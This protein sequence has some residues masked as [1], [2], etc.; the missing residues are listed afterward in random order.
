MR[1][2]DQY[3]EIEYDDQ[4]R[5]YTAAERSAMGLDKSVPEMLN[6]IH[7]RYGYTDTDIAQIFKLSREH[8]SRLRHGS[9]IASVSLTSAI[10]NIYRDILINDIPLPPKAYD[11][12]STS[13]SLDDQEE[14]NAMYIHVPVPVLISV[15][16]SF[17]I[18]LFLFVAVHNQNQAN[19]LRD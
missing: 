8:V 4:P 1:Y 3:N 19:R 15:G 11:R 18:V 2:D 12:R 17:L 5:P 10:R 13:S 16:V 6:S 9:K 14:T 7:D